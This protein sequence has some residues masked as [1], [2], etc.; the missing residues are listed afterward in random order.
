VVRSHDYI[1]LQYW[2][3]YFYNDAGNRHEG[4]WEMVTILLRR[5]AS[6]EPLVVGYSGHQSGA[7]RAWRGISRQGTHPLVYVA[8]GS[9]AAYLD[10]LAHGYHTGKLSFDKGLPAWAQTLYE[11]AFGLPSRWLFF[12][13]V[14]DYTPSLAA[15]REED[16]NVAVTVRPSVKLLP[17][18]R[19]S[20][21]EIE[22][23]PW[24]WTQLDCPWGSSR[25]GLKDFL[26]PSPP[27]R[28]ERKW[29]EPVD[30]VLRDTHLK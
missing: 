17:A 10:H 5:H 25:P 23:S 9:H 3:L 16:R 22:A 12:L 7:R 11:L 2:Y 19:P 6:M 21:R 8:R 28:Q 30:W 26:G 18:S 27:W 20:R 15:T 14:R 13:G 24:W 1:A 29:N 4:D